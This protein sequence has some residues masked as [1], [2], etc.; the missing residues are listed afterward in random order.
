M[1]I[2][3]SEHPDEYNILRGENIQKGSITSGNHPEGLNIQR[4]GTSREVEH[5]KGWNIQRDEYPE[6]LIIQRE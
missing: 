4:D 6:G 2:Q 1:N 5:P 3:G